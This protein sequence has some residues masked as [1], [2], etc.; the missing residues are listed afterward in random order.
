M[1][2]PRMS[3]C[4][5]RMDAL[6]PPGLHRGW[7][8]DIWGIRTSSWLGASR[9]N[10]CTCPTDVII[11][12]S[13]MVWGCLGRTDVIIMPATVIMVGHA[14][15]GGTD[16]MVE[17]KRMQWS[18]GRHHSW[19]M[20]GLGVGGNKCQHGSSFA[21]EVKSEVGCAVEVVCFVSS[22]TEAQ[23]IHVSGMCVLRVFLAS[24]PITQ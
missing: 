10:A 6:V 2:V 7:A 22:T 17:S 20:D 13:S 4:F 19:A 16:V 11:V 3:S 1:H 24:Q 8:V 18:Y 12:G 23:Q 15:L 5:G 14:G 9:P 21:N